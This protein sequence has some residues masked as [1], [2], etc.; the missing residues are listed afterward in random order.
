[1]KA[2]RKILYV[3][4]ADRLGGSCTSLRL[5]LEHLDHERFRPVV[6]LCHPT[7]RLVAY[8]EAAGAEVVTARGILTFEHTTAYSTSLLRPTS[9]SLLARSLAGWREAE[10]RT[11]ALVDVV[12][13]D[14]VHLNSAVLVPSARALHRTRTPFVWHVREI[15]A[16]GLAGVR[17]QLQREALRRWPSARLFHSEFQRR[18]WVGDV[19]GA[20][21]PEPVDSSRFAPRDRG[22]ARREL[23]IPGAA[24]VVLY[25]GGMSPLKGIY[26]LLA[27]LA[28]LR[29]RVPGLVALMPGAEVLAP[30]RSPVARAGQALFRAL[31]VS[32]PTERIEG[33]I[34]RLGLEEV[35]RRLPFTDDVSTF[36]AASDVVVFPSIADHFARPIVE[37]AAMARPVVAS[38]FPMIEEVVRD[39]ETALLV[40]PGDARALATALERVLTDEALAA[41]LAEAGRTR[42]APRF[43]AATQADE[44]MRLYDAVL[45]RASAGGRPQRAESR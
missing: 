13:P 2:S 38:R 17:A 22:A 1:V 26:E 15:P 21:I 4:H 24:K 39:G 29:R 37:A 5:L 30:G 25:V 12:R 8:H 35:C 9:W 45:G 20:V 28:T 36:V 44:T 14:L 6:A 41:S 19:P 34:P 27:A 7:P 11:L 42:V 18:R 40:P 16:R 31:R 33:A 3:Q 23:G 32:T 10:R 43:D